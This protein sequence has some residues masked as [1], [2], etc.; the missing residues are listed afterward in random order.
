ML[1]RVFVWSA[2]F[3]CKSSMLKGVDK[4]CDRSAQLVC[5]DNR[6]F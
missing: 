5:G 3:C 6:Q 1:V 4:E 2:E